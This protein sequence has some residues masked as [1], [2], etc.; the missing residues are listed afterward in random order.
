MERSFEGLRREMGI[1][2]AVIMVQLPF[3]QPLA[4]RLRARF[5]WKIV[6]DCM[7]EH[8][9]F[10]TN[11]KSMLGQEEVLARECD[12]V[13]ATASTLYEK[14]RNYNARC[15]LIPNAADFEHFK[16]TPSNDLLQ[17]IKKPIIGYYGAISDWFDEELV[18]FLAR[19]RG[20][21]NF[22]LVGHTFGANISKLQT[23]RTSISWGKNRISELPMYLYW[24]DV[25][26]IPFKMSRL[27][28]ATNPVKFYEFMS[29][30][31]KVV[32]VEIPEL[33]PFSQYLYLAKDKNEFLEEN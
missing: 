28:E 3:W 6:Y 11:E 23:C 1:V 26:I 4:R 16:D 27:I 33:I 30:G 7:D 17:G 18:E 24:F 31:K 10:S 21:W 15:I 13:V 9:G 5:G 19:N 20:D 25:C 8:S 12:L 29:S 32:S 22:V 14:M 2:E